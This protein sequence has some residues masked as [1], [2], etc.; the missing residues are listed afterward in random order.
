VERHLL[1]LLAFR[2]NAI[3]IYWAKRMVVALE[4]EI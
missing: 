4:Q 2:E 3:D 1:S